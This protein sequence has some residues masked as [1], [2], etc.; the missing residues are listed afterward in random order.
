MSRLALIHPPALSPVVWR[1]LAS[2]L[3]AAGH[4]VA[5]PD[6]TGEME[7]AAS[8]WRRATLACVLA[9]DEL[10]GTP[11]LTGEA[12]EGPRDY[13]AV[14]AG[15]DVLVAYS[16]AGVLMPLVA[17]A[18]PPRRAVF[19]DAVVPA[20]GRHTV[21]SEQ[22]RAF[23]AGLRDRHGG[24]RLPPWTRW[25]GEDGIAELLPD[26]GLRDELDRTAPRLPVDFFDEAVGV[27]PGWE[28]ERIDYVQLSD[29]YDADATQARA[30]GWTVHRLQADHLA[31]A[32]RPEDVADL[33]DLR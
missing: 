23:A 27:A 11:Q 32:T 19:L 24:D 2:V 1:P 12:R 14:A 5:L 33:L 30:R 17:N 29:A 26:A 7:V 15:P 3:R 31:V 28:P 8:W 10:V 13:P 4:E 22:V 25:W 20:S 21:P 9:I 16:G 18:R 6:Y